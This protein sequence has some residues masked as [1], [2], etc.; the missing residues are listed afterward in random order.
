MGSAVIWHFQ[1]SYLGVV[2]EGICVGS[3][4]E[5]LF[6]KD[7]FIAYENTRFIISTSL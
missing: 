4:R 6:V 1:S 3:V 2:A 7:S 5:D